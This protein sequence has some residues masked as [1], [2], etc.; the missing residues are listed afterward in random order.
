M[1]SARKEPY[2]ERGIS[3]VPCSGCGAPSVYQWQV[4][5]DG[6]VYRGVCAS[7]DY[8]VNLMVMRFMHR[9]PGRT[10]KMVAYAKRLGL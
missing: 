6:N 3:R 8:E 10:K 9:I 4:C 7:C 1:T 2:T 5:A